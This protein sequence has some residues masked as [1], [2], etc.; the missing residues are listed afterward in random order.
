MFQGSIILAGLLGII[1]LCDIEAVVMRGMGV[2]PGDKSKINNRQKFIFFLLK[3]SLRLY[4]SFGVDGFSGKFIGG[5][6]C[7][8]H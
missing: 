7:V 3:L 8:V 2:G 6:N 5:Y 4:F 1:F